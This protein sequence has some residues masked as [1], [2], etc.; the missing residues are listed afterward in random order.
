LAHPERCA[1][2]RRRP[3]WLAG[4]V[5]RGALVQVN[6]ESLKGGYGREVARAA[7]AFLRRG[8]VHCLGSDGHSRARPAVLAEA[9]VQVE[10][11]VGQAAAARLAGRMLPP[12]SVFSG[13]TLVLCISTLRAIL[14]VPFRERILLH[15]GEIK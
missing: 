9:V 2:V 15:A 5:G 8:L 12:C 10:R 4:A 6:G 3:D 13:R 11:L 14:F 7:A 1:G